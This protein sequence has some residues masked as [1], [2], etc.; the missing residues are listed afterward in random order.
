MHYAA[1]YYYYCS[2]HPQTS[3]EGPDGEER[4]SSALSLTSVIHEGGWSMPYPPAV[5]PGNRHG[6]HWYRKPGVPVWTGVKNL[7]PH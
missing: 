7:A 3:H 6:T 1:H 5:P 2:V 4:H